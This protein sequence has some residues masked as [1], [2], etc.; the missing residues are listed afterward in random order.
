MI[1]S[2]LIAPPAAEP[3]SLAEAKAQARIE[4][5]DDDDLVQRLIASARSSAEQR[6]GRALIT[7]TWE[8]RGRP[9]GGMIELRRWPA[10]EVLSVSAGT[11]PLDTDA[12]RAELGEFP[13]IE[14]LADR[15]AEV[16]VTYVAGYGDTAEDVPAP[17]RQW[18]LVAIDTMYELREAE[19]TGTIVSRVGYVDGL[20]NDYRVPVG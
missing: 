18:I 1:R 16:A 7:Q 12:W 4:H 13:E 14:L 10:V 5:D 9:Q 19:V 11:V 8:Q 3:V 6:T 15:D 20:L 17:I 2:R